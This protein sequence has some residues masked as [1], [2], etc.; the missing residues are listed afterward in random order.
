MPKKSALELFEHYYQAMIFLLPMKDRKFI[1]D[2]IKHNLLTTSFKA[3]LEEWSINSERAS[4]FLDNVIKPGLVI[5]DKTCFV[6][7]L[8]VIN[9]CK[10]DKVKEFAKQ[11][12]SQFDV[13]AKCKL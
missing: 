13:N 10:D 8:T 6:N 1:K 12:K 5:G 4:Y 11:L 7:L 3:K 9:N 2:L